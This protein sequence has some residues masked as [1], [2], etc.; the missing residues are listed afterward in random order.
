MEV[1][2]TD[3]RVNKHLLQGL[4]NNQL[5]ESPTP[6]VAKWELVKS[7]MKKISK[8]LILVIDETRCRMF[9]HKVHMKEK[10]LVVFH[11]GEGRHLQMVCFFKKDIE[12]GYENKSKKWLL[13][14]DVVDLPPLH[15]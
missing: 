3:L 9:P 4:V 5:N 8:K 7:H 6:N 12:R 13:L 1:Q 10:N 2:I 11:A 15:D 14:I